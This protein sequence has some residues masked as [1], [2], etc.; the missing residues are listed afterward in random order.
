MEIT[1]TLKLK[2]ETQSFGTNGFQKRDFVITTDEQ[3]PQHINIELHKDKCNLIDSYNIGD[4]LT[5]GINLRGRE[6]ISPE[7]ES[8]YFNTLVAW[9][10]SKIVKNEAVPVNLESKDF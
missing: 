4:V 8:K 7:G 3:Y 1:G 5:V 6:W 10:I 2:T 9:K